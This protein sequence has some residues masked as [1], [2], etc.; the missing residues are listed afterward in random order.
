MGS[1]RTSFDLGL[2]GAVPILQRGFEI[3]FEKINR[4]KK[5]VGV[6]V[7][8]LNAKRLMEA[9]RGFGVILLFEGDASQLDGK[10]GIAGRKPA[11]GFE[12]GLRLRKA[13]EVRQRNSKVEV[14]VGRARGQRF[15]QM[16][17]V[18]PALGVRELLEVLLGGRLR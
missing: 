14:Q 4:A 12:H 1:S 5:I 15:Q 18:L 17:D 13:A 7:V 10:P 2:A 8:G 11:A 6:G 3:V 16:N 9:A